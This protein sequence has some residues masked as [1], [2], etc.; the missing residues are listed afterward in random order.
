MGKIHFILILAFSLALAA[1][2]FNVGVKQGR[3]VAYDVAQKSLTMVIDTT[4]DQQDSPY[5]GEAETFT[6]PENCLANCPS[7]AAG[8]LLKIEPGQKKIIYYDSQS[9]SIKEMPVEIVNVEQDIH[10]DNARLK[11]SGDGASPYP[12]VD[13]KQGTVAIYSPRLK[14]IITLK[15]P[16]KDI[17]LPMS[18]WEQGNEVRIAYGRNK[19]G[20][21]IR[22]TNLSRASIFSR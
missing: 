7:P 12:K 11:K 18:T 5:S 8:G 13:R 16:E 20:M 4:Q 19:P 14:A 1:C 2:E 3:C 15:V 9:K 6:L 10:P 22:F 17:D 21:A